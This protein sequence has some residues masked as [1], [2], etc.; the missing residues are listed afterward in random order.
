MHDIIRVAEEQFWFVGASLKETFRC[1]HPVGFHDLRF[2][3][4]CEC[5]QNLIIL[6]QLHF[7]IDSC[8]YTQTQYNRIVYFKLDSYTRPWSFF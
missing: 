7:G 8:A 1:L 6:E 5:A 4:G 2:Y 3:S